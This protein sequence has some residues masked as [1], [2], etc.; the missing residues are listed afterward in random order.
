MMPHCEDYD[1]FHNG[2]YKGNAIANTAAKAQEYIDEHYDTG[3][4]KEF[5]HKKNFRKA[6]IKKRAEVVDGLNG[7]RTALKIREFVEKNK[8]RDVKLR[9]NILQF[10]YAKFFQSGHYLILYMPFVRKYDFFRRRMKT[11][12]QIREDQPRYSK[13]LKRFLERKNVKI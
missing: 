3:K 12:S 6:F 13:M 9:Y 4:I 11:M 7:Y 5:E 8:Y 10:I 2:W 1:E